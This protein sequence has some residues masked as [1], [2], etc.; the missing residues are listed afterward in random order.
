M[1]IFCAFFPWPLSEVSGGGGTTGLE[2]SPEAD[3]GGPG[4]PP[5]S[6]FFDQTEAR[7]A[8]KKFLGTA[9]SPLPP[10]S[11]LYLEVWIR[12]WSGSPGQP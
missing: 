1:N 12:H 4:G 3:P 5:P 9:H 6:S 8:E 7:R 11:P 10:P 2:K